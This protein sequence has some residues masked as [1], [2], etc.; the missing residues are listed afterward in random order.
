[1][2]TKFLARKTFII[3]LA[4]ALA[5]L[6][7]I[8]LG[9][10]GSE[11][12][13]RLEPLQ[14]PLEKP[15]A[16]FESPLP[17][18]ALPQS[19]SSEAAQNALAYIAKRE[20]IP[21]ESLT[22]VAD[23]PTEYPALGQKFQV[24]TL[25]DNRPEGEVYKLLVDLMNG[26]VEE[27]VSALLAAEARAHQARY[28]KLQPALFKRLQTLED[29]DAVPVA[30]WM[31]AQPGKSLADQQE[32]AFEALATRYPEAEAAIERSGKPME[33]DDPEL[34][35]RIEADYI[36]LMNAET[37]ARAQPL[38]AALER[39][40]FTVTT[41]EGM[42]SFTVVLP[43]WMIVRLSERKDVSAVYLIEEG[44]H[45]ELDSA[46]PTTLAPAVW[47]RGYDGSGVTIAILEYG[48][49]DPNNSF[50][51]HAPN[52]RAASNGVQD[53]TT[54]VA[55]DAASFHGL[56]RG[57]APE[58][59]VL[60]AGHNGSQSDFVKALQWA[61]DQGARVVN[62]SEGWEAD[63]SI[64]WTDRAF[65]YWARKRSVLLVKAAGNT[66]GSITSP[67]K[68][69]NVLTVGATRDSGTTSWSDDQMW[70]P[71]AF[72]NPVSTHNDREKPEVVTVGA[73]VRAVGVGDV[74]R[75]RS[76][77]SHA[78]PQ[79]AGLAAL[80]IDRNSSL[81]IWPEATRAIIMASATHNIE[82]PS[83]I[84]KGQGD[85]RDGAGAIN[86]DLADQVA[87]LRGSTTT[88][89]YASC[90]WATYITNVNFPVGAYQERAF[91]AEQGDLIRVVIVWW[92]HA[93]PEYSFDRL[94]TDLDL[95]I[96]APDGQWVSGASSLSFDNNYE[97]VQFLAPQSGQY[98]I[99]VHK[100]R[101]DEDTNFL[102]VALVRIP[103]P[104]RVHLPAVMNYP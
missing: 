24:V 92:A 12:V 100:Y 104:Y 23:H 56:Y 69:W 61:F 36:A 3:V 71:S 29:D 91:Y 22:I 38:V 99:G 14:S 19:V 10:A 77:T 96:K 98:I 49:V 57:M 16:P 52:S 15:S 39:R 54:R 60:S 93:D 66:F 94:D 75:T 83:I 79:V 97:M 90:W 20:G 33:V 26:R 63:D 1:M 53:H 73:S 28:G 64:N 35:K 74:P 86:A 21:A 76:G 46:V 11:V 70:G 68:G 62:V 81:E 65:D 40:G 45:P 4:L 59:T 47:G 89:C 31:T 5:I 87:R 72:V 41:Y 101:A 43:K 95:R 44:P 27:D 7:V 37:K 58:A 67:G 50:L 51:H 84:V 88:T 48:N 8:A 80:L 82:G 42:P 34:A 85:L 103:L 78:A 9:Q 17:V 32:V 30:V 2:R 18:P 13:A 102:G 6:V 55:S 25:V